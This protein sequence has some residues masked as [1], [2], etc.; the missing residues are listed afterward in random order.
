MNLV[1]VLLSRT[2]E[3]YFLHN[4]R[5]S[6]L[7]PFSVLLSRTNEDY[8]LHNPRSSLLAPRSLF[9]AVRTTALT[10]KEIGQTKTASLSQPQ[11]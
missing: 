5:S 10:T 9:T 6:L 11:P 4:P 1:S 8:F 3:D 7:A 2:N